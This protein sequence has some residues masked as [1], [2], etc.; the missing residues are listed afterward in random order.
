MGTGGSFPWGKAAGNE[1]N[2]SPPSIAEVK[3][4]WSYTSTLQYAFMAW[5][6]VK[7]AAQ[8]QLYLYYK[9]NTG[10]FDIFPAIKIDVVGYDIV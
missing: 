8:G 7:K 4:A 2:H 3:N 6:S 9:R 1:A 10:G 5:C